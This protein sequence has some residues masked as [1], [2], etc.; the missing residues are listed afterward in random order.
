MRLTSANDARDAMAVGLSA[1]G[2]N[3]C[4]LV[5]NILNKYAKKL[6]ATIRRISLRSPHPVYM[7][8]PPPG[9]VKNLKWMTSRLMRIKI[10]NSRCST[11]AR[12]FRGMEPKGR[13]GFPPWAGGLGVSCFTEPH[14]L[15]T[16]FPL[17]NRGAPR[18]ADMFGLPAPLGLVVKAA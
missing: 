17:R 1:L 2:M 16:G 13:R 15:S 18:G 5:I 8:N 12:R 11:P 14:V 3:R 9:N 4:A 7:S 6:D 10:L